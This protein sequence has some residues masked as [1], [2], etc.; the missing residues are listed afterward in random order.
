MLRNGHSFALITS[1]VQSK[2][3]DA[4]EG[5]RKIYI[6]NDTSMANYTNRESSVATKTCIHKDSSIIQI[7]EA[8]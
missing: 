3:T 1:F 5:Q 4:V 7:P 6:L 8:L 2:T